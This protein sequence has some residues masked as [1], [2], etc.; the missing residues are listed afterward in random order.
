VIYTFQFIPHVQYKWE[1]DL[2]LVVA[3]YKLTKSDDVSF[4]DA[5]FLHFRHNREF[6]ELFRWETFT[7][8]QHNK[9]S[10]LKYRYLAGSGPRLRLV[11]N[12]FR[13]EE[14]TSELQ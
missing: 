1:R 3:D 12:D 13:S 8:I 14:H 4:E 11:G 6:T 9:M 5:A 2:L 10:K 7:Q